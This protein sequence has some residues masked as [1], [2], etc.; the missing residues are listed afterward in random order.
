MRALALVGIAEVAA[1]NVA[2]AI[3]TPIASIQGGDSVRGAQ[4]RDHDRLLAEQVLQT[5]DVVTGTRH[6]QATVEDMDA[7]R[8]P[9]TTTT[10]LLA[11]TRTEVETRAG[12]L[13]AETKAEDT[14]AETAS[15]EEVGVI[16]IHE[17]ETT[18][19]DTEADEM[20][21]TT[22]NLDGTIS[23]TGVDV[24]PRV[25]CQSSRTGTSFLFRTTRRTWDCCQ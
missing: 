13:E 20:T 19:E 9:A 23:P 1:Q 14:E 12:D 2:I 8:V 18:E 25:R 21:E 15:S 4:G 11:G 6:R 22:K 3:I 10:S 5:E 17:M 24:V 7:D 16:T